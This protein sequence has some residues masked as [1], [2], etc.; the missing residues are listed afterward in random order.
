[1][2]NVHRKPLKRMLFN[3]LYK[4]FEPERKYLCV[5]PP[6]FGN[7]IRVLGSMVFP[8]QVLW[9]FI[10]E[11]MIRGC[12]AWLSTQHVASTEMFSLPAPL[13]ISFGCFLLGATTLHWLASTYDGEKLFSLAIFSIVSKESY[14]T[15]GLLVLAMWA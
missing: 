15:K 10:P 13:V 1:M 3:L 9:K 2:S 11:K 12:N 4:I 8:H 5:H 7:A 6:V 14:T